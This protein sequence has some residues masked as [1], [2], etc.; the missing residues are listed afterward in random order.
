MYYIAIFT[1]WRVSTPSGVV[2]LDSRPYGVT[3]KHTT[4]DGPRLMALATRRSV[5]RPW[6]LCSL[7][8]NR[9]HH[10]YNGDLGLVTMVAMAA[11]VTL[12]KVVTMVTVV[13][14]VTV[15]TMVTMVTVVNTD[16]H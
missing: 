1:I 16:R 8:V 13:T 9:G 4:P 2:C 10:G 5:G 11:V 3:T 7:H 6:L 15:V 14:V 12:V